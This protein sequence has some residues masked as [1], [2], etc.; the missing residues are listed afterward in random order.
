MVPVLALIDDSLLKPRRELLISASLRLTEAFQACLQLSRMRHFLSGGEREEMLES[1]VN[2]H[3]AISGY[4]DLIR[5]RVNHETE[6]PTRSPLDN[7]AALDLSFGK[8]LLMKFDR[9]NAD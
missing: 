6:I 5:L 7:P 2:S 9:F 8:F 3:H 1:W 4:G